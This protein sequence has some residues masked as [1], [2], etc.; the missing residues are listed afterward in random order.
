MNNKI[1]AKTKEHGNL[2]YD[3]I[4]IYYDGPCVFSVRNI[5]GHRY[6]SVLESIT[7]S[8]DRYLLVPVSIS[9]YVD[10]VRNKITIRNVFVESEAGGVFLL[11][12]MADETYLTNLVEE[13]DLLNYNLPPESEYLEYKESYTSSELLLESEERKVGIAQISFEKGDSHKQTIKAKE[14]SLLL[15]KLQ[16]VMDGIYKD[17]RTGQGDKCDSE[18]NLRMQKAVQLEVTR[19]YAA[20]FGIEIESTEYRNIFNDSEFDEIMKKFASIAI[21]SDDFNADFCKSNENALKALKDYYKVLVMHNFAYKFQVSTPERK[22]SRFG[23]STSDIQHKYTLLSKIDDDG[24]IQEELEGRLYAFDAK[25]KTF[26][27]SVLGIKEISGKIDSDFD[28]TVFDTDKTIKILVN[29]KTLSDISGVITDQ[30]T[31]LR[32]IE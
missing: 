30:Y 27:F 2:F 26:K 28:E 9:R 20:S 16:K 24:V 1:F 8:Y 15:G 31:L 6:I 14:L 10:F 4:F 22:I 19:S 25:S 13:K 18:K 12:R 5:L 7:D 23:L 32:I 29:K 3:E 17:W 11:E 21:F